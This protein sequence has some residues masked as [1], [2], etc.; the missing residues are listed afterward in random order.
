[1]A[2]LDKNKLTSVVIALREWLNATAVK[3]EV[4]N[5]S[6]ADSSLWQV[7]AKTIAGILAILTDADPDAVHSEAIIRARYICNSGQDWKCETVLHDNF[8]RRFWHGLMRE[9][10]NG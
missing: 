9:G 4:V 3:V 5:N 6:G 2:N 7:Q 10:V 1:M 8:N